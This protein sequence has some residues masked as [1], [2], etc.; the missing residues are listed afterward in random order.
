MKVLHTYINTEFMLKYKIPRLET[1]SSLHPTKKNPLNLMPNFP[2]KL[3]YI[4]QF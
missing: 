2:I 1:H 3:T 4:L